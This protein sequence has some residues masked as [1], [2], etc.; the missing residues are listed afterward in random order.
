M[1]ISTDSTGNNDHNSGGG[2]RDEEVNSKSNK[3]EKFAR[4]ADIIE[5]VQTMEH[6]KENKKKIQ[7][8]KENNNVQ[9]SNTIKTMENFEMESEY[10]VGKETDRKDN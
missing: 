3:T 6:K 9:N 2:H 4:R 10:R 7:I 5:I 1:R 8:S